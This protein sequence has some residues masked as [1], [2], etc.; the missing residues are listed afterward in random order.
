MALLVIILAGLLVLR[1]NGGGTFGLSRL[2]WR[3]VRWRFSLALVRL[4]IYL[5][6]IVKGII[7]LALGSAIE[8]PP[9][10]SPSSL[11]FVPSLLIPYLRRRYFLLCI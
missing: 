10:V 6:V 8:I 9:L 1:R 11:S 7:W 2:L 5:F 3:Q 4:F